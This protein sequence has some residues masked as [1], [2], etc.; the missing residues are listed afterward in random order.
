MSSRRLPYVRICGRE[1]CAIDE[2][3]RGQ[4]SMSA[5]LEESDSQQFALAPCDMA[6]PGWKNRVL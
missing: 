4:Y 3:R 6:I 1:R 5:T 2:V